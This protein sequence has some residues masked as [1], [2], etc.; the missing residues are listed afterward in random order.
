MDSQEHHLGLEAK[1]FEKVQDGTKCFDIRNDDRTY[2]SGDIIYFNEVEHG[3][4]TGRKAGPF[5]IC[6]LL[7]HV[8]ASRHGLYPGYFIFGW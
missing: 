3:A 1:Y 7:A 5:R 4:N 8:E 2:K 6:F